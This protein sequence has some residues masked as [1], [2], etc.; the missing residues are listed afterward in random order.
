MKLFS[1]MN[2]Q[3]A[4]CWGVTF[5]GKTGIPG[6]SLFDGHF[7][8]IKSLLQERRTDALREEASRFTATMPLRHLRFLPVIPDAD[9]F[10][11]AGLNY[12]AHA[13]ESG[14]EAPTH[15]RIFSRV[16]QSL[17]G[18][19]ASVIR[20]RV[21]THFDFEGELAVII[22]T[23]GRHI[24]EEDALDHVFGFSCFMDGSVRDWQKVTTT[25]GKNFQATG[26]FGPW[27]V[28]A[29]ELVNLDDL[30]VISRLNGKEMQR[31][32]TDNLIYSIPFLI[33][34]LSQ[35]T[36]LNPG[37][38]IATGTPEGVGQSRQP[39]V[40]M[41]AGDTIEVEISRIGILTNNVEDEV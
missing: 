1:Y 21:S 37:D 24:R 32:H 39:A 29:D 25:L 5:D 30:T 20:P 3:N 33:H 8:S 15:P 11:C 31:G 12:K 38:V 6:H 18:H 28:T 17:A 36:Q 13:A 34:Y 40:W 14:K 23:P 41:K 35:M 9:Q 22:G 19:G 10:Y 16:A 4:A 26:G 2:S 7:S 27:L